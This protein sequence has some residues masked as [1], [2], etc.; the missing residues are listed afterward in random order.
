MGA[1]CMSTS[2]ILSSNHHSKPPLFGAYTDP[3]AS[4]GIN[5]A[6]QRHPSNG[7]TWKQINDGLFK[8]NT[9]QGCRA[10][11][12]AN[13]SSGRFKKR[14][15]EVIMV[16]PLEAKRLA[17]A[18]MQQL[19]AGI[20]LKRQRKIE[21]INGGWAMLGLTAGLVIEA[22]TGNGILSQLVGY[23]NMLAAFLDQYI[24]S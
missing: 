14:K 1:L 19:Q 11:A 15:N 5:F 20:K 23:L 17:E 2:A 9:L 22:Q 8:R 6:T 13:G 10:M 24:P 18:Q 21:A 7:K 12:E 3:A 16:D 4:R